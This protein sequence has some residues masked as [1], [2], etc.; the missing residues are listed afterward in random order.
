M[1][2]H[3]VGRAVFSYR[4]GRGIMEKPVAQIS[5]TAWM[6]AP[7]TLAVM[8]ALCGGVNDQGDEARFVGGCV[9]DAVL[10]IKAIDVDIATVLKPE[11]VIKRLKAAGL[12]AVPTGIDHGTVTAVCDSVPFEITTLRHD[13]ET[14]GRYAVVRFTQ[15]WKEDARRR[16]FTMNALYANVRGE[17]YDYFGGLDDAHNGIVRFIDDADKRI[18]EDYLRILRFY[19]FSA[20]Y[21]D[22]EK[23]DVAARAA[24]R[25]YGEK[26]QGIS[27]ER[28]QIE[29][30]KILNADHAAPLWQMMVDDQIVERILPMAMQTAALQK[31]I[32][33]ERQVESPGYNMRRLSALIGFDKKSAQKAAED[34]KLSNAGRD[35]L[36]TLCDPAGEIKADAS[37]QVLRR[38][39]YET[40]ID[41][42]RSRL[43]LT[44]AVTDV[45]KDVL[46]SS[47]D[48]VTRVRLPDFPVRGQDLLD[49]GVE[50]GARF[51]QL[52][53]QVESWWID[54]DF[55][56]GRT[57]ALAKLDDLMR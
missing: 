12:K 49:R 36:I 22:L 42:V 2:G 34:L 14:D 26:L 8:M 37:P 27:A 23:T 21:A 28:I 6:D 5:R 11:E 51:G 25:K 18:Q 38:A 47:Y 7:E 10:N 29:I 54:Q 31:L 45:E 33:L 55:Q 40:N 32:D 4:K 52:L 24:C 57:A 39:V 16:D 44:A 9:R 56:P 30:L 53:K 19:R 17:V 43:L 41:I 35:M 50:Q 20:H 1:D 48:F 15:E 3:R 13:V 46:Q